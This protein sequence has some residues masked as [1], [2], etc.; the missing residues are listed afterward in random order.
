MRVRG[1]HGIEVAKRRLLKEGSVVLV[2]L[3][4]A[5]GKEREITVVQVWREI[6]V[7]R[8]GVQRQGG[9]GAGGRLLSEARAGVKAGGRVGS[10]GLC[11][12]EAAC[13]ERFVVGMQRCRECSMLL[14][15]LLL[16]ALLL[17]PL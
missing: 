5:R 9:V 10:V 14:L 17:L 1:G 11:A 8:L 2:S 6:I 7:L 13:A 16:L 15:L 4:S 3:F 12:E